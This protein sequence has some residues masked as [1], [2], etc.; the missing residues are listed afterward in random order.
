MKTRTVFIRR[1]AALAA[2]ALLFCSA[3][4]INTNAQAQ[5]PNDDGL[6][7]WN[8]LNVTN[9]YIP[10]WVQLGWCWRIVGG[11]LQI[12]IGYVCPIDG[13]CASMDPVSLIQQGTQALLNDGTL[14]CYLTD[15]TP[16][17]NLIIPN[18]PKELT[19]VE[20]ITQNCWQYTG[21]GGVNPAGQYDKYAYAPCSDDMVYSTTCHKKCDV[22]CD[23]TDP[24]VYV[25]EYSNCTS[26]TEG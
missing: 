20:T 24:Y 8:G 13:P 3:L 12:W 9:E 11:K 10:C 4:L 14:M 5:C 2:M 16:P 15:V 17:Y 19:T 7:P 22:C 25:V 18:C 1:Y 6:G 21:I 23:R 26:W